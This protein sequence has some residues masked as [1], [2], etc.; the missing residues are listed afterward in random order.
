MQ[1]GYGM[2]IRRMRKFFIS[3][4]LVAVVVLAG[5]GDNG[6][7]GT[8]TVA[9]ISTV[10][11]TGGYYSVET[12]ASYVPS[13]G[14]TLSNTEISYFVVFAGSQVVTKSG[15]I[16]SGNI[17]GPFLVSQESAPVIVTIKVTV[18]GL[19]TTK[20]SSIPATS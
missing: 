13:T 14:T 2:I 19:T 15:T 3:L 1:K 17:I 20:T 16:L 4:L 18:G 7:S 10:D 6:T 12:S 9:D 8:L 5:C 11:L